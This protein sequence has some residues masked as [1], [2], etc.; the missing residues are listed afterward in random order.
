MLN[1]IKVKGLQFPLKITVAIALFIGFSIGYGGS[2]YAATTP[3]QSITISPTSID[4]SLQPGSVANGSFQIINSGDTEYTF[5]VYAAPY[6]VTG[7]DYNPDFT[8]L[9]GAPNVSSWVKLSS[10]STKVGARQSL[11]VNYSIHVPA[12]TSA[13]GYYAVAFAQTQPLPSPTTG[14]V[15]TDRVGEI[16]YLRVAGNAKQSGSLLTWQSN[17]L[18]KPPLTAAVRIEDTGA[19]NFP[20]TVNIR[21]KNVFG[22]TVYSFTTTRQILPQTVRH[23]TI[24][25][26]STPSIGF[27]K[28]SGT[29]KL[30]NSTNQLPTK[31]VLVVSQTIRLVM[32]G[33]VV[34]VLLVVVYRR[35]RAHAKKS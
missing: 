22:R 27:F 10:P 7:E 30:L 8:A 19:Y 18:Q 23:I 12:G 4:Q 21:V 2:T 5:R 16:F 35:F 11:T 26:K 17:F 15:I 9:P 28:V 31:Y 32:L 29:A 13:G 3:A 33:L 1:F 14:V 6:R 25:W 20:T 34:L 24:P